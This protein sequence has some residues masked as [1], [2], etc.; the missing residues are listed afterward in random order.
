MDDKWQMETDARL[1]AIQSRLEST[2]KIAVVLAVLVVVLAGW[3]VYSSTRKTEKIVLEEGGSS[4]TLQPSRMML[5]VAKYTVSLGLDGLTVSADEKEGRRYTTVSAGMVSIATDT[6][7]MI[8][9]NALGDNTDLTMM[10]LNGGQAGLTAGT[11]R[12]EMRV[13]SLKDKGVRIEATPEEAAITGIGKT[14]FGL[15]DT[16]LPV[17]NATPPAPTPPPPAPSGKPEK[18]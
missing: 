6:K 1:N 18:R 16:E 17:Q 11:T 9:M 4:L 5:K 13:S 12:S 3:V 8:T 14:G 10:S 7:A 2:R 15:G